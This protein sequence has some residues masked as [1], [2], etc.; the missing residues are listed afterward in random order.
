VKL[1]DGS[2]AAFRLVYIDNLAIYLRRRALHAP[3]H[4]PADG[5]V[6]RATHDVDIQGRR[7]ARAVSAGPG[8]VLL[9]YVPFYFG[10]RSPMLYRLHTGWVDGYTEGQEPIVTLVVAV[11]EIAAAGHHLVFTDGQA[12]VQYTSFYDELSRLGELDWETIHTT[13]WN[14]T[15]EDPDRQRR[16]QAEFPAH[17]ELPWDLVRGIA[18]CNDA[19][20]RRVEALLSTF[21][22][23]LS[24]PVAIWR[25]LYY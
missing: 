8:G 7:A 24:R 11:E 19:A 20:V 14:K 1:R 15:P 13:S 17:R 6:W 5:E 12:L 22:P 2:T 18:V 25:D 21:D 9:D 10:P 3:N 16:K 23:S 4:S